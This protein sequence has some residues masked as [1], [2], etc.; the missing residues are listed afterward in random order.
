VS[1]AARPTPWAPLLVLCLGTAMVLLDLSIVSI[2]VPGIVTGLQASLDQVLWMLNGYTLVFAVLLISASRMGDRFGPRTAFVAGVATFT[3]ASAACGLA[4][5]PEQLIAARV[6]QGAG[7][8]LL[9]PQALP[10]I[11]TIFAAGRRGLAFGIWSAVGVVASIAGP[12][13]GGL[14]VTNASWRW[15]FLVNL[16]VGLV[17]LAL[18]LYFVPDVRPGGPHRLDPVGLVLA[19]AGLL[20]VS[21]ALIEGERYRW[22]GVAGVISIPLIVAAGVVLLLLFVA[23]DRG[24]QQPLV[25][26]SLMRRPNFALMCWVSLTLSFGLTGLFLPITIHLQSALGLTPIEA[27]LMFVPM[28]ALAIPS[29]LLTARLAGGAA[30]KYVL[31]A[32]MVV[33]GAGVLWLGWAAAARPG[34]PALVP[35]LAAAGLGIGATFGPLPAIAMRDVGPQLA[36]AASGT[37]NTIRQVGSLLGSAATGAILENRL[38][39][40]ALPSPGHDVGLAPGAF[41]AAFVAAMRP[42]LVAVSAVLLVGALCCLAARREA[43][44]Q[45]AVSGGPVTAGDGSG[46]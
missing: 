31:A 45:L 17:T 24:R 16:P 6:V 42:A 23:W 34:W 43:R 27:G 13:A 10:I 3:L 26:P 29:G 46:R 41:V 39:G 33:V 21:F 28:A 19:T 12:I 30:G 36:G 15:I 8:A 18:T 32:G 20:C 11:A 35:G 40:V 22:A 7:G 44:P 9:T 2:A 25:P 1:A 5:N 4:Q 38:G 37:L 14:I